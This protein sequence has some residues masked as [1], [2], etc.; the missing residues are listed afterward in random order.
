MEPEL[1][2]I[3]RREPELIRLE[4]DRVFHGDADKVATTALR[5]LTVGGVEIS[6]RYFQ[7]EEFEV[8][9]AMILALPPQ[10]RDLVTSIFCDSKATHSYSVMVRRWSAA[11]AIGKW[12]DAAAASITGGHNGIDVRDHSAPVLCVA[13][14]PNW[15]EV[16]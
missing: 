1:R 11:A 13:I 16:W 8:M 12:L 4:A 7:A 9:R 3:P 5:G 2:P 6:S 15:N 10:L 14:D